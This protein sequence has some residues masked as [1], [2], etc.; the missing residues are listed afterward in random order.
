MQVSRRVR[1]VQRQDVLERR[2]RTADHR[3]RAV[4][5]LCEGRARDTIAVR[6]WRQASCRPRFA[7]AAATSAADGA[8]RRCV[9]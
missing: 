3:R 7:A 6:N 1:I 5:V 4:P 9:G 8:A 2:T